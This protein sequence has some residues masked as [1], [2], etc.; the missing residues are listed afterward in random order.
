MPQ[1]LLTTDGLHKAFGATKALTDVSLRL[2]QG[3]RLAVVGENGAGKSTLMKILAGVY[4]PDE[5][6]M[7]FLGEPYRPQS[8]AQALAAG[9][10]IVYQEPTFF[11][12]LTVLENIFVGR[13]I[14]DRW[15]NLRWNAMQEEAHE[16]FDRLELPLGFLGRRMD[17]LSLGNQQIVLIAR[18]IHQNARVLIL[19][20]PTSIL[21]DA[22]A[23]KLF[24]LVE[25]VVGAGSGVLYITHR[26]EEF[27]RVA[28][29]LIVLKDGRLVG[30]MPVS[31]AKEQRLIELMSGR[32]LEQVK[33][34]SRSSAA[35]DFA[36][37][38]E[39]R[40][41]SRRGMYEDVSFDVS[42]GEIVGFYGLVGAG[43]TET[44][45][46][47]FG[48]LKPD[49]GTMTLEGRPFDPGSPSEAIKAGV[50]Y[51]PEDRKTQGIFPLMDTGSNLSAAALGGLASLSVI[52]KGRENS[53]VRRFFE[54]L[55][56]KAR[57]PSDAILSL[58]GGS[59]QK[60]VLARWLATEPKMLLLDE[61]TRG[62]DVGTK[63]E[64]HR[65]IRELADDGLGIILISSELPELLALSDKVYV[66]HEG[67]MT[68][69]FG[70]EEATEEEVL[71][72]TMGVVGGHGK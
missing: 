17:A 22:E 3:E 66:L 61:P 20:E 37:L 27:E 56:I 35:S 39:V 63:A 34:L 53:L 57:S 11:P 13:E 5:G 28:D 19:D 6:E 21:T 4:S 49:G 42:R 50:V 7:T 16:L 2:A 33:Q 25:E 71:R 65:L 51:V 55:G 48:A 36:S 29:R 47:I 26:F 32:M 23:N 67:R 52:R 41:L 44:A 18:A 38:L 54:S 69:A 46:S 72:A 45:L 58:S 1:P 59:Q 62:I 24:G 70:H 68:A 31:E 40:N 64:I 9:L 30:E 12:Q 43:R 8:P 14:K 10:S 15:G 60:V